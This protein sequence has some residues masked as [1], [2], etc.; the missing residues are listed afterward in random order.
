VEDDIDKVIAEYTKDLERERKSLTELQSDS[1]KREVVQGVK[2]KKSAMK[3]S[4]K[5][6][7]ERVDEFKNLNHLLSYKFSHIDPQV[8]I[9]PDSEMPPELIPSD[10][11]TKRIRIAKAKAQAKLKLLQLINA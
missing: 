4:G 2:E 10:V 1:H 6:I 3:I 5:T 9:I 8:C 11:K 7:M